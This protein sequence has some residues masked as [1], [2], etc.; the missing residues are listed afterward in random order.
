MV[1]LKIKELVVIII[2]AYSFACKQKSTTDAVKPFDVIPYA[3]MLQE[4]LRQIDS[5]PLAIFVFN[6]DTNGVVID[7]SIITKTEF[8][9]LAKKFMEPDISKAEIKKFYIENSYGDEAAKSYNFNYTTREKSQPFKSIIV[10][11]SKENNAR[12]KSLLETKQYE[13]DGISYNEQLFWQS[14]SYCVITTVATKNN[15]STTTTK[16]VVWNLRAIE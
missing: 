12:F 14:N 8:K 16:K 6:I 1:H 10:S 2:L 4:D 5:M 15:Q 7:S 13:L 3:L 11:T 9:I